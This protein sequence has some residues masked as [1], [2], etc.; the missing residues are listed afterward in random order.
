M[1]YIF[2]LMLI[3]VWPQ[4]TYAA[5]EQPP[6]EVPIVESLHPTEAGT[7]PNYIGNIQSGEFAVPTP[8]IEQSGSTNGQSNSQGSDEESTGNPSDLGTLTP[9]K[10]SFA[11][12]LIL[13]V[14][15]ILGAFLLYRF[16]FRIHNSNTDKQ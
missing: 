8:T 9:E 16:K 15:V 10:S 4:V 14:G 13:L 2:V 12:K 11:W 1:K 6:G 7:A 5:L 3:I